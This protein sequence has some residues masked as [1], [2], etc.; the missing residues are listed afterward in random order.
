M[1][2]SQSRYT[3]LTILASE[4]QSSCAVLWRQ[5]TVRESW[6]L[7]LLSKVKQASLAFTSGKK[8]WAGGVI[9]CLL[10][11]TQTGS[12]VC[13]SYKAK[14]F[15]LYDDLLRRPKW[16]SLTGISSIRT[17]C[18]AI[19]FPLRIEQWVLKDPYFS[20]QR[21]QWSLQHRGKSFLFPRGCAWLPWSCETVL[22]LLLVSP[23]R[24]TPRGRLG[25]PRNPISRN[26]ICKLYLLYLKVLLL[27]SGS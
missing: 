3:I 10:S 25:S 8:Q 7:L 24:L 27:F 6:A 16:L 21:K 18:G 20:F 14:S 1:V 26:Q 9:S 19:A 11:V 5:G 23:F 4:V 13:L 15:V 17:W 12:P 2:A 22:T